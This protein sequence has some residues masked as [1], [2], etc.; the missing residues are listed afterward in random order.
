MTPRA[1]KTTIYDIATAMRISPSTVSIVLA[2]RWHNRRI[3]EDTANR[4]L[5]TAESMGYSVNLKARGLRLQQSGLAG[6]IIPHYRNRFFAGLAESFEIEARSRGLCP[7]V[8]STQ[9]EAETEFSTATTLVAHQV[10]FLFVAGVNDPLKINKLCADAGIRSI[11]IDLPGDEAPSVVSDNRDA[12]RKLTDVM[13]DKMRSPNAAS[14]KFFGGNAHDNATMERIAGVR[15]AFSARGY[16]LDDDVFDCCGY[17]PPIIAGVIS[18]FL[19]REGD[20]MPEA[21]FANG[22]TAL[23][24]LLEASASRDANALNRCIIG[25]YD[26]DPFA[27]SLPLDIT[28]VRQDVSALIHEGFR[29][30]DDFTVGAYPT[31]RIP[32]QLRAGP[33]SEDVLTR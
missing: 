19:D 14:F 29:L 18:G 13:L 21:I 23:E 33:A 5:A 27:A 9:R 4:V 10:E 25:C 8:V 26:W 30:L 2:G 22:I 6:M 15:D 16:P 31:T 24:G 1:N 32:A 7:I 28:F 20:R 12:A 11:N 17:Q 3:S